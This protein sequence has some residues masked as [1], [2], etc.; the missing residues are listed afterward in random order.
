M[1]KLTYWHKRDLLKTFTT[2]QTNKILR[3]LQ[4]L[5]IEN[6]ES[7]YVL[8]HLRISKCLMFGDD[9]MWSH[10]RDGND[11]FYQ[12]AIDE[13]NRIYKLFYDVEEFAENWLQEYGYEWRYDYS[14]LDYNNPDWIEEIDDYEYED[15]ISNI[16]EFA[17]VD[18]GYFEKLLEEIYIENKTKNEN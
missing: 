1:Q 18:Y 6:G 10:E 11:Y 16:I 3:E 5:I 15:A 8:G 9:N 12:Y 17:V 2:E 4:K 7:V 14:D 13:N